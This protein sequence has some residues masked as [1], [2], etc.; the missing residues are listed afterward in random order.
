MTRHADALEAQQRLWDRYSSREGQR[1]L[2]QSL[3]H[4]SD[5]GYD[6]MM[7]CTFAALRYGAPYWWDEEIVDTL[8]AV[9][10]TLQDAPLRH[11]DV[12]HAYGWFYLA[13]PIEVEISTGATMRIRGFLWSSYVLSQEV[14][15]PQVSY[16]YGHEANI[17]TPDQ[18]G[19]AVVAFAYNQ[20]GHL[21]PAICSSWRF[22]CTMADRDTDPRENSDETVH[23]PQDVVLLSS[24]CLRM[25]MSALLFLQQRPVV[26]EVQALPRAARRR[27][28]QLKDPIEAKDVRVVYLR[29]PKHIPSGN[30]IEVEHDHR[31]WV[32]AHWAWRACGE[33]HQDRRRVIIW[34]YVKG[35]AGTPLEPP[36]RN[37]FA[38]IR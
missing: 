7:T 14:A 4:V 12:P 11:E 31:W 28:E 20:A 35:P 9:S 27:Q 8:E 38:V 22:G 13:R 2:E 19:I 5:Y 29:K 15:R 16:D 6:V 3:H 25:F 24:R 34:P 26:S 10:E 33:G 18:D 32:G 21:V 37:L 17:V 23:S 30:H 36:R 1:F